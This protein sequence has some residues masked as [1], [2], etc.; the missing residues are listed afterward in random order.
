MLDMVRFT[1]GTR[2]FSFERIAGTFLEL[3]RTFTKKIKR[4]TYYV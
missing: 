4:K 1:F 2:F 3:I